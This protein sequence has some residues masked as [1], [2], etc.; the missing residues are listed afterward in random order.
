MRNNGT[1]YCDNCSMKVDRLF[2]WIASKPFKDLCSRCFQEARQAVQQAML[3]KAMA[4]G[5]AKVV[6]MGPDGKPMQ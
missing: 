5:K 4:E 3:R 1:T 2:V 6:R